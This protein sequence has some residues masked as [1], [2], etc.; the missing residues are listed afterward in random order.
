MKKTIL[1]LTFFACLLVLAAW[2]GRSA[3]ASANASNQPAYTSDG[4]LMSPVNYRDWIFLT[5]GFGMNYSSGPGSNPMFTNVYVAPE[6]YQGFKTAGK[7]PDKSMFI[8]EIYSPASHGSINKSG[9][10]QDAFMG[11]DVEVKDSS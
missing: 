2:N 3:T 4:K 7:W 5:S 8:V 6:A 9:H 11:L 10:Y 1:I